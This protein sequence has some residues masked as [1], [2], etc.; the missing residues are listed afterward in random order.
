MATVD[1]DPTRRKTPWVVRWRDEQGKQRKRGFPRKVDA[2]RYRAEVEHSL[3]V[4]SYV[5][6][7]AGREPFRAYAERWREA[8]PHRPNTAT[9]TKSQLHRHTYPV[10][11]HRPMAAVRRNELQAFVTGLPLAPSSVRPVWATVRAIFRAAHHDRVIGQD[12]TLGVKLPELPHEEI[13]PLTLDQVDALAAAVPRRYRNLVETDAGSGLRQGEVFGLEV[14]HVDFLRRTGKVEQQVQPS[15]GGEVV[16]C[17]LKNRYSYRTVP[18]DQVVIDGIAAHL[19]EF[20]AREVEVLDT[21]G[22]RP[23]RRLARFIYSDGD[24]MPLRRSGFNKHVWNPARTALGLT[25]TTT[26]DLRHFYASALIAAGLSPKAVARL[27]GHKDASMTLRVYA[28]LWP[29]D[30]DR[31]RQAIATAFRR[32][33]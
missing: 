13:V 31:A 11:G 19:A 23:V 2:D 7:V 25:E 8:Q 32:A 24:G 3:N 16:I 22:K 29:D 12:P 1:K 21:T 5:D 6:P 10:I 14:G 20:P 15:D 30:E 4:G 33:A 17:P 26:H 9:R 18:L 28:H 27:L